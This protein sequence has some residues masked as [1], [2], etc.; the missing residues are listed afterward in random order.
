MPIKARVLF[1]L[2][3]LTILSS[4]AFAQEEKTVIR[5][6]EDWLRLEYWKDIKA[7]SALDFSGMGLLDAPAGKYG[8]LKAV[9]GHFEFEEMPGVEQRFYG[10]NLCNSANYPS[11]S[12]TNALLKR[13][14][15][16][17][18]NS[19]RIHHHD[20]FWADEANQEKLDYLL[21][22]A[23]GMGFY[24]TTDLY[25]SRKV[26]WREIGVDK[27]GDIPAGV[28]K[29]LSACDDAA[30]KNWCDF[31]ENFLGHVNRYTGRAYKDE[32]AICLISLV[33][34]N[35]LSASYKSDDF[36]NNAGFLAWWREFCTERPDLALDSETPEKIWSIGYNEFSRWF[37]KKAFIKYASFVRNLGCKALLTNDNNTQNAEGLGSSS[38]FDY[39]DSHSYV[40]H[41]KFPK[42]NW[43]LPSTL[44]NENPVKARV[45][46]LLYG[47]YAVGAD[48]PQVITEW[49]FSGPGRYRGVGGVIVGAM[50]SYMAWDGLWRFAYSHSNNTFGE[51]LEGKQR[52]TTYFDLAADPLS[53][54]SERAAICLFLR[55]DAD[56]VTMDGRHLADVSD[57]L[58]LDTLK[59]TLSLSTSCTCAVFSPGGPMTAG[60]LNAY[61]SGAPSTIWVSALDGKEI[62]ESARLLLVHLTDVQGRWTEFEDKERKTLLK[63]G[64]GLVVERGTA[65]I[66]LSLDTPKKY[67]VYELDTSGKRGR[68]VK[69]SV[70][71]N[72]LSFTVSTEN[73]MGIGCIYYE[74]VNCSAK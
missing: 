8:H 53:Q 57:Q 30:F 2:I 18:Y 26:K 70:S 71:G 64:S 69:T 11:H 46:K 62:Q 41:P 33:N 14:A 37:Q 47:E 3:L 31:T 66:T 67:S 52:A 1:L 24:I 19:I 43:G 54:A 42:K 23:V 15:R 20:N 9:G 59:G 40:D 29:G 55:K 32:P 72:T 7:G 49:S 17:G 44:T 13:L 36:L 35:K 34:E 12:Q 39:I 27:D 58:Q 73:S 65:D 28:F 56:P 4:R 25:V 10:V 61:I 51:D 22:Q 5:E 21:S 45:P 6:S 74:I 38:G 68:K 60:P 16:L 48:I 50:S 63:W